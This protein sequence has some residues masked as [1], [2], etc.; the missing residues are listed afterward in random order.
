MSAPAG[1]FWTTVG[2]FV[3]IGPPVGGIALAIASAW[4]AGQPLSFMDWAQLPFGGAIMGYIGGA[5]P[6]GLTGL[7]AAAVSPLIPSKALWVT[8]ATAMGALASALIFNA[9]GPS[10][11]VVLIGAGA[12]FAAA[13]VGLQV[14]PRQSN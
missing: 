10:L 14:R 13:L 8:G 1:S 11:P 12:A 3:L 7:I 9:M 5:L 6:A 4:E 2:A